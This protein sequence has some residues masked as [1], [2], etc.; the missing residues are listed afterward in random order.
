MLCR[1][2][3]RCNLASFSWGRKEGDIREWKI[4]EKKKKKNN[5]KKKKRILLKYK[6]PAR[7]TNCHLFHP[8][9]F[10]GDC[11]CIP[12]RCKTTNRAG[13]L[14]AAPQMKTQMKTHWGRAAEAGEMLH[15][16]SCPPLPNTSCSAKAASVL[17]CWRGK[18]ILCRLVCFG[19]GIMVCSL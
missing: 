16:L 7:G 17:M 11:G 3:V 9:Q 14:W 1:V 5:E 6:L 12:R 10:L 19:A 15:L 4:N 8:E 18:H 2:E 13:V